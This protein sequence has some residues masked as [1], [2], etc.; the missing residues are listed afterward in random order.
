MVNANKGMPAWVKSCIPC[1]QSKIHRH[2]QSYPSRI[3]AHN[4]RYSRAHLDILGPLPLAEG[5]RILFTSVDRFTRWPVAVS[6][7][8]IFSEMV[9]KAFLH[10]WIPTFRFSSAVTLDGGAQFQSKS[11]KF[12]HSAWI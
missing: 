7:T 9:S 1:Q 4:G 5:Y 11:A 12:F 10:R 2:V 6:I 8:G 3:S